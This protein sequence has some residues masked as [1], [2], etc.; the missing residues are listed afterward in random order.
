M[1]TKNFVG[2]GLLW[3]VGLAMQIGG[4]VSHTIAYVLLGV[5]FTWTLCTC[6]YWWRHRGEKTTVVQLGTAPKR[7][8]LTD[9]LTV[10]HRRLVEIQRE[11]ASHTKVSAKQLEQVLPTLADRMGIVKS[12]DWHKFERNLKS[13]IRRAAPRRNFRRPFIFIEF[14]KWRERVHLRALSVAVEVKEELFQS[15]EWAFEDGI[16]I[17][18]W[19]DGYD[20]GVKKLRDNDPQWKALYESISHYFRDEELRKLIK[21]HIDFS[22]IYNNVSLIVHYSQKFKNNVFALMLHEALIGSP[23]SP[24]EVQLALGEIISEIKGHVAEMQDKTENEKPTIVKDTRV[25]LNAKDTEEAT[26]MD[27]STPTELDNVKV[28]M[29]AENVKHA[30][31]L[32][33]TAINK[34]F[35][36]GTRMIVCSCGHT[37]SSVT[38]HGY[39]PVIKCPKCGKE[40]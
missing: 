5:A 36:I 17:S 15:Q 35:A 25:R 38:T 11:K 34:E 14:V 9:T 28:D 27:I 32:N 31:G 7:E 23:I 19:L 16:K 3:L 8:N 18:K 39:K 13:R 37:F 24:V 29:T 12:K 10:M 1:F 21:R 30:T 6:I 33:V 4:W 20:W 40:Y 26:G 22:Y 2:N